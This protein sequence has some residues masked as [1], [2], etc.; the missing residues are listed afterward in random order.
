M[1]LNELIVA[2]NAASTPAKRNESYFSQIN[3]CL[4]NLHNANTPH[5]ATLPGW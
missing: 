5:F 2:L 1:K 4:M 3:N